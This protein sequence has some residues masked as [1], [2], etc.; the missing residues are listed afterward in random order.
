MSGERDGATSARRRRERRLCSWWRHEQQCVRMALT[1]AAHH[2]S[3]RVASGETNDGLRAQQTVRAGGERSGVLKEP[4]PQG[5]AVTSA[6][7]RQS[8]PRP[9][10]S[11]RRRRRRRRWRPRLRGEG[12]RGRRRR[13][14]KLLPH[15]PLVPRSSSTSAVACSWLVF[16]IPFLCWQAQAAGHLGRYGPV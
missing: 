5:A 8:W 6:S 14:P 10:R 13:R 16:C 12:K 3:Q 15:I 4:Q 1:A 2:S 7:S 9:R 11:S